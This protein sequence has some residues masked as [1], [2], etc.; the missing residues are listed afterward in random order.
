M[1]D[2]KIHMKILYTLVLLIS[3]LILANGQTISEADKLLAQ[4]QKKKHP[5]SDVYFTKSDID[6]SFEKSTANQIKNRDYSEATVLEK[7]SY[8]FVSL[9]SGT[10]YNHLVFHNDF[11]KISGFNNL[12]AMMVNTLKMN[13]YGEGIFYNDSKFTAYSFLLSRIGEDAKYNYNVNYHD[14]KYFNSLYF[15]ESQPID[16]R[17]VTLSVPSWLEV[18]IIEMNFNGYDITKTQ[19]TLANGTTVHT[20]TARNMPA[21]KNEDHSPHV[22]SV[23]PH[24]YFCFK[25]IGAGTSKQVTML[26]N[27][28][29]LYAWYHQLVIDAGNERATITPLV[30]DLTKDLSDDYAK[31]DAMFHWVQ[32]HIRYIAFENGIMGF[33]P[34]STQS[35]LKNGY[36][37]CKGQ[38]NLLC[39]MLKEAGYD[40]RLVWLGTK[41]IPYNYDKPSIAVD[42]H[43]ICVVFIN[44]QR[45]F[46]DPTEVKIAMFDYA[47]RIQGRPCLIEDGDKYIVDTIPTFSHE[48]NL[49][50]TT[51]DL[52]INLNNNRLFGTQKIQINGESKVR[53]LNAYELIGTPDQ[54]EALNNYLRNG[55]KNISV[56]DVKISDLSKRANP[57]DISDSI[58]VDNQITALGNELYVNLETDFHLYGYEMESDRKTD[59]IFS[60][61]YN[62]VSQIFFR[63]PEGYQIDYLP[64]SF[65]TD[66]GDFHFRLTYEQKGN[67]IEYNKHLWTTS[68]QLSKSQF[69][70]W[71]DAIKKLVRFYKEQIVLKK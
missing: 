43:V 8:R 52:S 30:Q 45:I 9:S 31:I 39:E 50:T 26:G 66:V 47:D 63:I 34:E 54:Q 46:L 16:Q 57:I 60:H 3:T 14:I 2:N 20:Y 24:L 29:G 1:R 7:K 12:S 68:T 38:A 19:K 35:V 25:S 42:N 5:D 23:Y 44:D 61:K 37:D 28:D 56:R 27:L 21:M 59:F 33:K 67:V 40:A 10:Y 22:A 6:V 17:V 11:I 18:E 70:A 53:F 69:P 48:R 41:G 64:E 4:E 55:D 36:G 62:D 32:E 65:S 71:N 15:T 49:I 13:H 51:A 58:F